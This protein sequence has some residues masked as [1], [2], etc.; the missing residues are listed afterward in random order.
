MNKTLRTEL[1]QKDVIGKSL[2][3]H[4]FERLKRNRADMIS[5][6]ILAIMSL[7]VFIGPYL[8]VHRFDTIYWDAFSIGP[9]LSKGHL[10]GTDTTGRDLFVR[11]LVGGRLSLMIGIISTLV[12][13]VIGITYGA[14]AG[15]IGGKVDC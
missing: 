8:S 14:I 9:S 5:L 4:A 2:W 11:V 6:T 15:Y 12:S 7:L 3:D 1:E 13:L 10:F